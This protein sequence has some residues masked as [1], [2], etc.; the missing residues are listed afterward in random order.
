MD[1]KKIFEIGKDLAKDEGKYNVGKFLEKSNIGEDFFVEKRNY[2][3]KKEDLIIVYS[4]REFNEIRK[5]DLDIFV[6]E[7]YFSKEKVYSLKREEGCLDKL[8]EF[9]SGYWQSKLEILIKE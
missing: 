5:E 9:K 3:Y 8:Y 2:F 4:V 7:G 1:Y 6:K